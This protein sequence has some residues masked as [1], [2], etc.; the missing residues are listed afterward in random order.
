MQLRRRSEKLD[1][2][3]LALAIEDNPSGELRSDTN[4][5]QD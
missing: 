2:D 1:P 5:D 3:Q 4:G